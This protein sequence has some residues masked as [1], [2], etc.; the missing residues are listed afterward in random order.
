MK[1]LIRLGSGHGGSTARGSK[2][3][4]FEAYPLSPLTQLP[5]GGTPTTHPLTHNNN[6]YSYLNNNTT[7]S[8]S[9]SSTGHY[10]P[11]RSYSNHLG[12][13]AANVEIGGEMPHSLH[14]F[15]QP[16]AGL[17]VP[18]HN[19]STNPYSNK[20]TPI[21]E[22]PAL[23]PGRPITHV[24]E[25][26]SQLNDNRNPP[27]SEFQLFEPLN[28]ISTDDRCYNTSNTTPTTGTFSKLQRGYYTNVWDSKKE[29]KDVTPKKVP[30]IDKSYLGDRYGFMKDGEDFR[31]THKPWV[32]TCNSIRG[33]VLV[34]D[35]TCNCVT[36]TFLESPT[37]KGFFKNYQD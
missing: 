7:G 35:V 19:P 8:S 6:N 24:K 16:P 3:G 20:L 31:A 34:T 11:V 30:K 27:Q 29:G 5:G 10:E 13:V 26:N 12:D 14:T 18:Q 17:C 9:S 4:N 33:N 23:P 28:K 32:P 1:E 2:E 36:V 37:G 21:S 25:V 22:E 15:P